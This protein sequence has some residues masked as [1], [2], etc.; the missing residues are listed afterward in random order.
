LGPD[1]S[2]SLQPLGQQAHTVTVAPHEPDQVAP[3]ATED[4][5]V[6]GVRNLGERRLHPRR[7]RVHAAAHVRHTSGQPYSGARTQA[8]HALWRSARGTKRRLSSSTADFQK[9]RMT[10]IGDLLR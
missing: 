2:T 1:E 5:D 9:L 3:A 7:Q 6:T 10:L 8:D 4:E